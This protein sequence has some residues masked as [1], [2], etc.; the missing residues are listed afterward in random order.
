METANNVNSFHQAW[1]CQRA[2]SALMYAWSY[3]SPFGPSM[4]TAS[5]CAGS[6][7]AAAKAWS[8]ESCE[9]KESVGGETFELLTCSF[10]SPAGDMVFSAVTREVTR[11]QFQ[12]RPCGIKPLILLVSPAGI[13]PA[14]Y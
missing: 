10:Q 12:T 11:A 9:L 4:R 7:N 3:I 14:T 2:R 1:R 8:S 6:K 5:S 13:E